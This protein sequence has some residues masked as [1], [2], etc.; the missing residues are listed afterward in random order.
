MFWNFHRFTGTNT[1]AAL[2]SGGQ[3]VVFVAG[4]SAACL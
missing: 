1:L 3:G 2:V 4:C